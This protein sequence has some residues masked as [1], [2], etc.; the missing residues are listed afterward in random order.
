MIRT[1]NG[2]CTSNMGYYLFCFSQPLRSQYY[3]NDN[4]K[5]ADKNMKQHSLLAFNILK[6]TT[7]EI[8]YTIAKQPTSR[9]PKGT[10]R[11]CSCKILKTTIKK[12]LL[13]LQNGLP[14]ELQ[15][16]RIKTA[17]VIVRQITSHDYPKIYYPNCYLRRD[18]ITN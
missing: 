4:I 14:C 3:E 2:E 13:R 6:T 7:K 8:T 5:I 17:N 1:F 11:V 16:T 12:L 10:N 9:T 15:K 18:D